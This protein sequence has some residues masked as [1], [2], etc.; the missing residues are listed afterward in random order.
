[1]IDLQRIPQEGAAP[2]EILMVIVADAGQ[3][4]AT[5]I[6]PGQSQ[7]SQKRYPYAIAGMQVTAGDRVYAIK[8][9]G[10]WVLLGGAVGGGA[11][12]PGGGKTGDAL[13]KNS[14]SSYDAGWTPLLYRGSDG[15]LCE[16]DSI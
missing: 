13:T 11:G 15:G 14:D 3:T 2:S 12:I 4:D 6:F 5:V 7:A 8:V 9:S 16:V 1:M 10:V